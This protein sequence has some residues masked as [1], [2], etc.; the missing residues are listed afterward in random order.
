ML[1]CSSSCRLFS[2]TRSRVNWNNG[3]GEL[4]RNTY[5]VLQGGVIG[6]SL[7]MLYIEDMQEYFGDVAGVIIGKT[8][9]N[10]LLQADDLVLMSETRTGLQSSLNRLEL[11]CRRKHIIL[12]VIK[13]KAMIFNEKYEVVRGVGSFTFEN[14]CISQI[15]SYN[16]LG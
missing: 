12:N 4:F 7:F 9:V 3:L 11:Y 13:T 6:T 2:K 16:T 1:S 14:K 5:G 10:H 8:R 15:N